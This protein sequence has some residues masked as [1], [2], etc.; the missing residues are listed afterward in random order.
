L[1]LLAYPRFPGY[2]LVFSTNNVSVY[3]TTRQALYV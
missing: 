2:M 3:P 1:R